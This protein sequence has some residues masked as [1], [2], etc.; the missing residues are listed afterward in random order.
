[1]SGDKEI[2]SKR[3]ERVCVELG[4]REGKGK[5]R[6]MVVRKDGADGRSGIS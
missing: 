5:G 3:K 1:M 2:E 4:N 6:G